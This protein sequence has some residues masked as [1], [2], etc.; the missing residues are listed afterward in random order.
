M[1]GRIRDTKQLAQRIDRGYFKRL[2]PIPLWR[3]ILSLAAVCG[4]LAWLGFHAFAHDETPYSG[5]PLAAKHAIL[6]GNC[7]ACHG[8]D[9]A[10]GRKVSDQACLSCHDGP[11]HNVAQTFS[12]ACVQCH[13]EHQGAARLVAANG[14][15]ACSN[16][17]SNLHTKT[18]RLSVAA[19]I[20]SFTKG[21][22]EFAPL[23]RG[24]AD[25][26][27]IKF[28]HKTHV[29]DLMLKCG[30]CHRPGG[31]DEAW[32]FGHAEAGKPSPAVDAMPG[33]R[34]SPRALMQPVNYDEQCSGCHQ[35]TFDDQITDAAPHDKPEVVDAFVTEKLQQYIAGHPAELKKAGAPGSAGDWVRL[36]LAADEKQLWMTTCERCHQM[37][38]GAGGSLPVVP[39]TRV[40]RRWLPKA[41][42]DHSAHQE[43]QC[44]SC[45]ANA[46]S[47]TKASDVLLPGIRECRQCHGAGVPGASAE[48]ST[49][50]LYHD[51]SRGRP[52][53]G[54]FTIRQLTTRVQRNIRP[55][56]G[57][58]QSPD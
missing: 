10:K 18:G 5:G 26:A 7:A 27:A 4:G 24:A 37:Q 6:G 14:S 1:P 32:N 43:L 15:Q 50:H 19:N 55:G 35:L 13:V 30:E 9:S 17:H 20:E 34:L 16:C 46:V 41:E 25:P 39:E 40:N 45:H 51:W 12:P 23:R 42:F 22:P 11:V 28:N 31:V 21:H 8:P 29:G 57:D 54:K 2:F 56:A 38:P 47:S 48:C 52:V 3:R 36:R 44:L 58:P 33:G 49:C 53:D